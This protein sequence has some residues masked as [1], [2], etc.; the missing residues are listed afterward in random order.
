MEYSEIL[1]KFT[2]KKSSSNKAQCVC[3]SH[4]D[5]KASLS[6]NY[7]PSTGKTLVTCQARCDTKDVL[8]KVGL[9]VTD[10]FDKKIKE[11]SIKKE[12]SNIEKIYEYKD[13]DG[14]VLFE[15]V[16]TKDKDF[17][18]RRIIDGA[19]IWGL[20]EGNYTETFKGSNQFS[21]KN[22]ETKKKYFPLQKPIL[23]NLPE[24]IAAVKNGKWVCIAEGEKDCDTLKTMGFVATTGSSGAGK[25]KW[26]DTYSQYFKG[27]TVFIFPDNDEA[28]IAYGKEIKKS[29]KKYA[30]SI[31]IVQ[32]LM[33]KRAIYQ[34]GPR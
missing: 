10:L 11:T 23:Y 29:L 20:E 30:Y 22:R 13:I 15:K 5:S 31:K 1:N 3:P 14:K 17:Y 19:I 26:L 7:N 8:S 9:T 33:L 6:V 12:D 28:G 32:R 27:A 24:V 4:D 18:Q 21:K 25:G 16:R 2:V 34:I